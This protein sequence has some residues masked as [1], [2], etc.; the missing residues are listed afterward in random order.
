MKQWI[1]AHH[2]QMLRA[3][4]I[5]ENA[6]PTVLSVAQRLSLCTDVQPKI[7]SLQERRSMRETLTSAS[8]S[9]YIRTE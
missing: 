5:S 7:S 4:L 1:S 2:T 9:A 8:N 3:D 6:E